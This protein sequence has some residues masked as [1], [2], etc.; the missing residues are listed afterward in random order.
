MDLN[1]SQLLKNKRP[2]KFSDVDLENMQNQLIQALEVIKDTQKNGIETDKMLFDFAQA[3][4]KSLNIAH[5]NTIM[6][7]IVTIV[8]IFL[9][10]IF[11][12]RLHG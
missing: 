7:G 12:I 5:R 9:N 2:K 10:I 11:L 8:S 3:T 6:L 4:N 1:T